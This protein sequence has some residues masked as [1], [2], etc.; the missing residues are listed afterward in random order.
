[1]TLVSTPPCCS[2]GGA[3][4]LPGLGPWSLCLQDRP[5]SPV[6]ALQRS[7]VSMCQS[8][9]ALSCLNTSR[10]SSSIRGKS[11][12]PTPRSGQAPSCL[13][14][15]P[16]AHPSPSLTPATPLCHQHTKVIP[17]LALCIHC[18]LSLGTLPTALLAGFSSCFR[19]PLKRLL[20]RRALRN[21]SP[22]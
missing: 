10:A 2:L 6:H 17:T 16:L 13:P 1:M 5:A 18:P 19:P 20:W 12:L 11:K 4:V 8:D 21:R 7:D 22:E 3:A 14:L 15:A 9:E